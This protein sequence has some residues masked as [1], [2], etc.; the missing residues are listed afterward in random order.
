LE[1]ADRYRAGGRLE[2]YR[3]TPPLS[4]AAFLVLQQIA[5]R[6]VRNLDQV[7]HAHAAAL[8]DLATL[9]RLTCA[10]FSLALEELA[11]EAMPDRVS[12]SLRQSA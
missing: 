11:S 9:A 1:A 3:G 2:N 4:D 8:S 7:S 12:A 6:G 5:R 10:L